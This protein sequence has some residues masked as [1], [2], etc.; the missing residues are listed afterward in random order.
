[1]ALQQSP[2]LAD[3]DT[4]IVGNGPSA[5]ILS[6][7]LHGHI[8]YYRPVH[9]HPD[10]ILHAKLSKSPRLLD[11]DVN[12]LTAHFGASR[13]SYSTQALPINVLL[14]TLIRPLADTE[15]GAV[16]SCVEWRHEPETA[17]KH[18][19]L[20][21]TTQTGGQ[22]ANSLIAAGADIGTLSYAEMLSLPGYSLND[23]QRALG[24]PPFAQFHRPARRDIADYL[25]AYPTAVGICDS[26][27][28]S[29]RVR[30]VA[31]KSDGFYIGSHHRTCKHLVLASGVSSHLL[32][33][34]PALQPLLQLPDHSGDLE[35]PLLVVGTGFS[36][37]D[38]IISTL[39]NRKIIHIFRW[40]PEERPSPLRACHPKAYPEYASVYRKMKEAA[41]KALGDYGLFSPLRRQKS[42]PF[43]D[44]KDW[45]RLYEGLPNTYIAKAF[46][47]NGMGKVILTGH[48]GKTFEREVS[49]LQYVIGRRGT[50]DYLDQPLLV[51]VLGP[52]VSENPRPPIS[53]KSLRAKV[54]EDLEVAANVFVTG[55]LT[56][57]TLIRYAFGGCIFA[58]REIFNR[59]HQNR[60]ASAAQ[61][62]SPRQPIIRRKRNHEHNVSNR[63]NGLGV[64]R[65]ARAA[66]I[67]MEI[68]TEKA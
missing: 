14:D 58:A 59:Q 32:P 2:E 4:I 1:M 49:N 65:E 22:W 44:P 27:Q 5:L 46:V 21:N 53:S 56:G 42:N 38:V 26:F 33:A 34:R 31:R 35:P 28:L 8:P 54:E 3:V 24:K 16:K 63:H 40:A 45:E 19:V 7:I 30:D 17:V 20:G 11:V 43:F 51:D 39:P 12:E 36:A 9:P 62:V 18:L 25:A 61:P 68:G 6:F 66:Y 55:S 23:H 29:T 47:H 48:D 37:A 57:D 64:N 10:P 60:K 41:A 52:S 13:L 50:L 15:P 67:D